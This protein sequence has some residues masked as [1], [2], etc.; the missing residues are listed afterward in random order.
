M[1]TLTT[2]IQHSPGSPTRGIGKE[3]EIK[4]IQIKNEEIKLP[5]FAGYIILHIETPK[6][7]TKIY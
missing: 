6:D 5:F 4:D 1:F 7:S 3:M 2:V